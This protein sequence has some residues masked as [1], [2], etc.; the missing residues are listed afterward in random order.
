MDEHY[1]AKIFSKFDLR[2]G[3]HQIRI[4]GEDIPKIA[5]RTH[6]GHYEF[7]IMSFGL[8][9]ILVTFQETMNQL[10]ADYLKKFIVVFIDDVLIYS[11]SLEEHVEHLIFVLSLLQSHSFF[12]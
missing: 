6:H 10:F 2:V 12:I 4:I 7:T 3:Y 5:F 8:T 9:N 11:G 1:V